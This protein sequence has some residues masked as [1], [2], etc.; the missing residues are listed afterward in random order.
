HGQQTTK[1]DVFKAYSS[2]KKIAQTFGTDIS[3]IKV[4]PLDTLGS[5]QTT[6]E[7]EFLVPVDKIKKGGSE[8]V[9][10]NL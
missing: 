4:N 3:E 7:N 9:T 5:Y 2:D 8:G 6:G 1:K 10:K